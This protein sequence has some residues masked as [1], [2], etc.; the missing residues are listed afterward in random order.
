MYITTTVFSYLCFIL[1]TLRRGDKSAAIQE[2][3]SF[4]R[5]GTKQGTKQH[6]RQKMCLINS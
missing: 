6:E 3:F 2:L 1:S 4:L 5:I